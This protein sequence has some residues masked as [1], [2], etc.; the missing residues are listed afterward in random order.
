MASQEFW[1][2]ALKRLKNMSDEELLK[3][4]DELGGFEAFEIKGGKRGDMM[5]EDKT[6]Y[7]LPAAMALLKEDGSNYI[8]RENH[9][10]VLKNGNYLF[11]RK[12][13]HGWYADK[14]YGQISDNWQLHQEP[15]FEVGQKVLKKS[16]GR[17]YYVINILEDDL[18]YHLG[19]YKDGMVVDNTSEQDLEPLYTEAEFKEASHE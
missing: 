4:V 5:R 11:E 8:Q 17:M 16:D 3:M 15:K 1:D 18:I 13:S 14:A 10:I 9:R 12:N 19:G 2:G 7:D 6:V